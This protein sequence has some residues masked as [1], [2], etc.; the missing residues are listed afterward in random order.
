MITNY[1]T[2]LLDQFQ[3]T[4]LRQAVWEGKEEDDFEPGDLLDRDKTGVLME[5]SSEGGKRHGNV[6]FCVEILDTVIWKE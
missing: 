3:T 6:Y 4:V 2:Y 5:R 1:Q